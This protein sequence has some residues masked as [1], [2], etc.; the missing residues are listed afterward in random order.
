MSK[1]NHITGRLLFAS[2]RILTIFFLPIGFTE[3]R[4]FS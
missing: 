2:N 4:R 1:K 3:F